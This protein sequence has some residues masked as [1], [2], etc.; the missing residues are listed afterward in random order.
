[1]HV[2]NAPLPLRAEGLPFVFLDFQLVGRYPDFGVF[3]KSGWSPVKASARVAHER[4]APNTVIR[5]TQ[6]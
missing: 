5:F 2:A 3:G 4:P 6:K 1:L